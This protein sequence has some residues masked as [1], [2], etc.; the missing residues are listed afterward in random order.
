MPFRWNHDY[1]VAFAQ[2][3]TAEAFSKS[4]AG[5]EEPLVLVRQ[6]EWIDEP[7]PG[8][9]VAEKGERVTEWRVKWLAGSKRNPDSI[10]ELLKHPR[11]ASEEDSE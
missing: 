8:H 10:K 11:P 5:A 2:Y 9:Y 7:Q 4:N 6:L 1:F 3:E